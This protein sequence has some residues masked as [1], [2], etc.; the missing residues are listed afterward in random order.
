MVKLECPFPKCGGFIENDDKDIAITLF[1]A[2]VSA[3]SVESRSSVPSGNGGSNRSEKLTRPKLS[4]EQ[5]AIGGTIKS[6]INR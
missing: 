6:A 1:N 5:K 3:H 4:I 2:H